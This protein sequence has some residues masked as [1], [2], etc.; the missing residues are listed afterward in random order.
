[1]FANRLVR[2]ALTLIA[3][4]I[5]LVIG[6]RLI[7]DI[8]RDRVQQR[9]FA[10]E[11][12]RQSFAGAQ[13][14][15]GPVLSRI[16]VEETITPAADRKSAPTTTRTQHEQRAFPALVKWT[17]VIDVEPRRR[18]LYVVQTYRTRLS[19]D[20]QWSDE[21]TVLSAPLPGMRSSVSCGAPTMNVLV[22]D[23]RGLRAVEV[24]VDGQKTT[25][26]P[27]SG[28]DGAGSGFSTALRAY[29]GA[30]NLPKTITATLTIDLVGMDSLSIVPL[31]AD[32]HMKLASAWPHP[33]FSG[34]FLPRESQVAENGFAASWRVSAL[35]TDAQKS[36]PCRGQRLA[37]GSTCVQAMAVSMVDPV[38]PGALSERAVKYGELFIVLTFV[39]IGLFEVLRRVRVHPIQYLLIGA[40]LA[41]F[42]LLLLS[43]SEHLSFAIAYVLAA[44]A[45]AGLVAVYAKSVLGGWYGALPLSMGC[46][47]L[48]AVLYVVLQ[49][50]Q[51]A[52]LAG[53]MLL[54]AILCVVM[55]STRNIH[56]S[57][58]EAT[59]EVEPHA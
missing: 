23:A 1:V 44:A 11:S 36:F 41:V 51:H 18:S 17:G 6:L 38:N 29:A 59:D 4:V 49:S 30:A 45:C 32:N 25:L 50:E 26:Q 24:T 9:A 5:V 33:S 21:A 19:A 58:L 13:V 34:A 14:I 22:T 8:S 57:S 40:A 56:W 28:I 7:G 52:L 3:V 53:S 35:A 47:A 12:V 39:G 15:A 31:A 37:L 48:Y 16:C 43:V 20:V 2:K 10:A 27:G 54:F 46:G 42:F 55:L